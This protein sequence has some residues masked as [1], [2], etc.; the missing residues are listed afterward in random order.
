MTSPRYKITWKTFIFLAL[1]L[2][3]FAIYI[4]IFSD[5][6]EVVDTLQQIDIC[7]YS[8]AIMFSLFDV[9][10][11]S[12]S[13]HV[14][15]KAVSVKIPFRKSFLFVMLGIFIDTMI[16]SESVSAEI[17]RIYLVN[18]EK[19]GTAGKAA[20]SVLVQRFIGIIINIAILLIAAVILLTQ[21]LLQGIILYA[22]FFLV[23]SM[24]ALLAFLLL[25]S[26]KKSWTTKIIDKNFSFTKWLT[27]DHWKLNRYRDRALKIAETFH[28]AIKTYGKSPKSILVA[29]SFS[30]ASCLSYLLVFC[31]SLM[32]IK[33]AQPIV[34]T[35]IPVI[36]VIFVSTKSIPIGI[37]FDIGLPEIVLSTLLVLFGYPPAI[38]TTVTIL[39]RLPTLWLRFFIGFAS[40]Q[41][42][43]IKAMTTGANER[44]D[45]IPK[46]VASG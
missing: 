23:A 13:W 26:G 36:T 29:S 22:V 20:A 8:A 17:T 5:I 35:T 32:A 6:E 31:F 24:L 12:L 43:G 25:L 39:I 30:I 44:G 10:L 33:P 3:A 15:L 2:A 1:G 28:S 42:L 38:A 46:K 14:L 4:F 41:W 21:N 37:P 18:K 27:R 11:Y 19:A 40:Q 45:E 9:L 34:W 16:P 7:F